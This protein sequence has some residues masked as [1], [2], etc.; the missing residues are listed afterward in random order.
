MLSRLGPE[1]D[2][3]IEELAARRRPRDATIS[4]IP[5]PP[6]MMSAPSGRPTPAL[7]V[8]LEPPMMSSACA[9]PRASWFFET[10]WK[11]DQ[12]AGSPITRV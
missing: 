9:S 7:A 10:F 5:A 8:S 2:R 12:I 4:P 3:V 11:F 1:V 6:E